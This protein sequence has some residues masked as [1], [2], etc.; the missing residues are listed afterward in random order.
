MSITTVMGEL[1]H[2]DTEKHAQGQTQ[3]HTQN[4]GLLSPS[5]VS[6]RSGLSLAKEHTVFKSAQEQ[7]DSKHK[8]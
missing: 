6:R 8:T 3:K 2:R 7:A 4:P 1:L 5:T